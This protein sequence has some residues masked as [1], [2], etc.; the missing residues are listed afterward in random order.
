MTIF[1]VEKAPYIFSFQTG[2]RIPV[3]D[4]PDLHKFKAK[5]YSQTKF[6]EK[7]LSSTSQSSNTSS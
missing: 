7:N 6:D 3:F 2:E 5:A 4:V 1:S